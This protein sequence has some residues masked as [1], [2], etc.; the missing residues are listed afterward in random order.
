MDF[1]VLFVYFTAGTRFERLGRPAGDRRVTKI[2]QRRH[3]DGPVS[4]RGV[5]LVF[6][7]FA[8][9]TRAGYGRDERFR[10]GRVRSFRDASVRLAR[11]RVGVPE[12]PGRA[13]RFSYFFFEIADADANTDDGEKRGRGPVVA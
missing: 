2:V 6:F 13:E 11:G 12:N 7:F 4:I 10:N 9:P 3:S 1:S 5:F 8:S